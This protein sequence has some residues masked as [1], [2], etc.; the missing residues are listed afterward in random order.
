MSD[1]SRE[2]IVTTHGTALALRWIVCL[3]GFA[4]NSFG[5][6]L[7]TKGALGTGPISAVPYVLSLR[8]EAVS[9]GVFT[10]AINMLFVV[11]QV[12]LLRRDFRARDLLQV[13]ANVFFSVCIDLSTAV[14]A[15]LSP[16]GLVARLAVVVLG[17]AVLAL[18]I[19]LEMAP[20]IMVVP[21][22][23]I[24][25]TI[26]RVSGVAFATCKN[27]FDLTL[28]A[29]ALVLSLVFFGTVRG[30]GLGTIVSAVLIGRFVALIDGHTPITEKVSALRDV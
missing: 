10:F 16:E 30:L 17:C 2:E 7:I 26:S 29:V 25:R 19:V 9:F 22:E 5:I 1:V 6:V 18:G 15:G 8:F 28:A 3:V 14:L 24:V 11:I 20:D 4:I 21:G 13:V 23:G 27:A 12:A